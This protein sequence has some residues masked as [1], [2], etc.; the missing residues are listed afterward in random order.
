MGPGG[1]KE[2]Q[3]WES[4]VREQRL[5][6]EDLRNA[7]GRTEFTESERGCWTLLGKVGNGFNLKH[8]GSTDDIC[9]LSSAAAYWWSA[10]AVAVGLSMKWKWWQ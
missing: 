10:V 5:R 4:L 1:E 3:M 6:E 8:I 2:K 9:F 7:L